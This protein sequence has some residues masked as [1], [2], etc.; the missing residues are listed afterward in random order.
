MTGLFFSALPPGTSR[1][2]SI[3]AKGYLDNAEVLFE[4]MDLQVDLEERE[5]AKTGL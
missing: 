2:K 3:D 1:Q 5:K 4:D